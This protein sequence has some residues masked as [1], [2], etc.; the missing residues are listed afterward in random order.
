MVVVAAD[1]GGEASQRASGGT[2]HLGAVALLVAH[3]PGSP[4]AERAE[5]A[6]RAESAEPAW[7]RLECAEVS[8]TAPLGTSPVASPAEA[9]PDAHR[10]L[11][12]LAA[13]VPPTV[14]EVESRGIVAKARFFWL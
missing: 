2:S 5:R 3:E 14:L 1:E 4:P 8:L 7:A 10:A 9:S 11:L 6:E 13:E 12:A